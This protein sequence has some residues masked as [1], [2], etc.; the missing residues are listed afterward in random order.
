MAN[1]RYVKQL[2]Q[3]IA[4]ILIVTGGV[5]AVR[6]YVSSSYRVATDAMNNALLQGDFIQVN[7]LPIT[8]N[9]G[10]N[11]VVLFQNPLPNDQEQRTRFLSH[12]MAMP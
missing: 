3:W 7:E 4:I 12:S 6:F 11:R 1:K 8:N 5:M 9:P 2:I 10:R